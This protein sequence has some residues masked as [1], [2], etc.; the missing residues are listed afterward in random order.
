MFGNPSTYTKFLWMRWFVENIASD[1]IAATYAVV[2]IVWNT[3]KSL[4]D[5]QLLK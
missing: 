1:W 4:L 5:I 3:Y 2:E